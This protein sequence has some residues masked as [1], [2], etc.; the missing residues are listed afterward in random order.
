MGKDST[1][2]WQ[3]SVMRALIARFAELIPAS[4]SSG[5][6]SE[7]LAY[8]Y[9][10][11]IEASRRIAVRLEMLLALAPGDGNA[12]GLT[13]SMMSDAEEIFVV[14]Q[15]PKSFRHFQKWDVED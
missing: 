7:A 11:L 6:E 3:A 13:E 5:A 4:E 12:D 14:L 2:Y 10:E 8:A 9:T 1:E 15:R